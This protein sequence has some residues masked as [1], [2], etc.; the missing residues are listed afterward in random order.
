MA[1]IEFETVV[2]RI[3]E[4]LE[5]ARDRTETGPGDIDVAALRRLMRDERM[6]AAWRARRLGA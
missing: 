6:R 5:R 4:S 1:D 2:G 3:E